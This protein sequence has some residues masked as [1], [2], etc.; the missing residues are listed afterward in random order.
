MLFAH[1]ETNPCS[2][3]MVFS[4]S[5][6]ELSSQTIRIRAPSGIFNGEPERVML[7]PTLSRGSVKRLMVRL[8]YFYVPILG[9]TR[10]RHHFLP[11]RIPS[12]ECHLPQGQPS[13]HWVLSTGSR[14]SSRRNS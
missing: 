5:A 14:N 8:L 4:R 11:T 2:W 10:L 6:S 1:S 3:R 13:A 9:P 7:S 12:L